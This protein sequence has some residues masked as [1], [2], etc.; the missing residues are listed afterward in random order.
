MVKMCNYYIG[1]CYGFIGIN[2]TLPLFFSLFLSI[3]TMG[4]M[5][6]T[7]LSFKYIC[8]VEFTRIN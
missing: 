7:L 5:L 2:S 6:T 4:K 3:W 8:M 1:F